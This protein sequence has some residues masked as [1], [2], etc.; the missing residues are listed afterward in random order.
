MG[1]ACH[2]IVLDAVHAYGHHAGQGGFIASGGDFQGCRCCGQAGVGGG[3]QIHYRVLVTALI[4]SGILHARR[5]VLV[6]PGVR[7]RTLGAEDGLLGVAHAHGYGGSRGIVRGGSRN[8]RACIARLHCRY[9]C[10][11]DFRPQTLLAVPGIIV[12][13][14]AFRQSHG[15]ADTGFAALGVYGGGAGHGGLLSIVRG[16]HCHGGCVINGS[17]ACI[18]VPVLADDRHGIVMAPVQ[19][20]VALHREGG[21]GLG[22]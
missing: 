1:D 2:G 21:V 15:D 19:G 13:R 17:L 22:R 4:D 11:V 12:G 3:L 8:R 9:F 5:I 7:P 20:H 16:A 18:P 10:I 14:I 6:D